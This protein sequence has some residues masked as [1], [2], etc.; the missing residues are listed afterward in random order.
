[1]AHA[2]C[3]DSLRHELDGIVFE[4]ASE[5]DVLDELWD[6]CPQPWWWFQAAEVYQADAGGASTTSAMAEKKQD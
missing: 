4:A 3:H 6:R 5:L 2:R 1:V